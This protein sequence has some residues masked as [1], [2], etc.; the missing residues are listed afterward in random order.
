[1]SAGFAALVRAMEAVVCED[2]EALRRALRS[3]PVPRILRQAVRHKCTGL[4]LAGIGRLGPRD[5]A[6]SALVVPLREHARVAMLQSFAVKTQLAR[7]VAAL[8]ERD[9]AYVL[10]KGAAR[11]HRGDED[12]RWTAFCDLD[13]L[14][15]P[16]ENARAIAALARLGYTQPYSGEEIERYGRKHHHLAPLL[17]AGD[18]KPIEVHRALAPPGTIWL[19]SDWD[20]LQ[21]YVEPVAGESGLAP[22]LNARGT[23]FH[24][25]VHAL[26]LGR[27]YDVV[28]LARAFRAD[29]RLYTWLRSVLAHEQTAA[30]QLRA[31]VRLA[32]RYARVAETNEPDVE[33]YIAWAMRREELPD[34]L[35]E[36]AQ[37]T[38]AWHADGGR[39]FGP[40]TRRA[41]PD[42]ESDHPIVDALFVPFRTAGRIATS[43]CAA[44]FAARVM[45]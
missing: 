32:A 16:A 43:L 39:L 14:V 20:A 25:A 6:V 4:L 34:V 7:I 21:R 18:W 44:G 1:M 5:P 3:A 45:A 10:L 24:L 15:R 40:A 17:H 38:E 31:G 22:C 2:G 41:L 33:R 35:R 42:Y 30:L 36:R 13:V 23:A 11:L 19:R 37:F 8:N 26:A 9:I 28:L 29:P 12:A 27:L